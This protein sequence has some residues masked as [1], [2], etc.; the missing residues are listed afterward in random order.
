M[1]VEASSEME[2]ASGSFEQLTEADRL[3]GIVRMSNVAKR[4]LEHGMGRHHNMKV[5]IRGDR[6]TGKSTLLRRLQ[7]LP[8]LSE[9]VTTP[10]I[11][12]GTLNWEI[13]GRDETDLVKIELWDIVDIVH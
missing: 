2:T 9:H 13:V 4:Q 12:V 10:E 6:A 1:G 3:R 11:A 7:G 5:I 8:Y